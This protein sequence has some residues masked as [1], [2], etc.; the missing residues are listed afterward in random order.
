VG[1]GGRRRERVELVYPGAVT[2]SAIWDLAAQDRTAP[3]YGPW[4]APWPPQLTR[5]RGTNAPG[6]P[7]DH[8]PE[9]PDH[10]GVLG[11]Q[12]NYTD[13]LAALASSCRTACRF[14]IYSTTRW[15]TPS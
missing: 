9:W 12:T 2:G 10:G 4:S 15:P 11:D 14:V 6:Q 13:Q 5:L 7:D 1:A 8:H 3:C